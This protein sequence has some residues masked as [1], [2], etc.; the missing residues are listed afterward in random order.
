MDS[1]NGANQ[2][3]Y[4]HDAE[5]FILGAAM[6]D[7]DVIAPLAD[8]ITTDDL[9]H[10]KHAPIWRAIQGAYIDGEP[11][12][13]ISIANRLAT[14][15][16]LGRIGG[17]PYLHD[18]IRIVTTTANA[19]HYARLV[20]DAAGLR[21]IK[22]VSAR[23]SAMADA[24]GAEAKTVADQASTELHTAIASHVPHTDL[25]QVGELIQPAF[26]AIERAAEQDTTDYVRTGLVDLDRLLGGGLRGGQLAIVA[27]RPG[28]GKSVLG[29][30]IARANTMEPGQQDKPPFLFFSLEMQRKEIMQRILAAQASVPLS[31]IQAGN[32]TDNEWTQLARQAAVIGDAPLYIDD[33]ANTTVLDVRAKARRIAAQRGGIRAIVFD[34]VQLASSSGKHERREREVA[35]LARGLKLIGMEM[36]VPV[37]GIAQLNRG[38]EARAD[39]MPAMSDLR[40]SGSLEQDA[41]IVILLFRPDYYD[42][43]N[44]RAGEIDFI[45]AKNRS[46]Q[47]DTISAAS[48]LHFARFKSL[49]SD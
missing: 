12:D 38:P 25:V 6:L 26:D 11:T 16:D 28:V 45:V 36:D 23:I 15:G 30:N 32:L 47:T 3:H 34:Y 5:S 2:R 18:L 10:P 1:L 21:R 7:A 35:E 13:A 4:N 37:V 27:G 9:H 19:T 33:T 46:G 42:K 48:Q 20:K 8:I 29:L 41:D 39:K 43:E 24:D 49:A 14:A 40:E 22:E 44:P 31:T 17:A